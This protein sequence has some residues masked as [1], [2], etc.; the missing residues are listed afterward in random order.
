[1]ADQVH[2]V[3]YCYVTVPARAGQGAKVLG[4]LKRAG[5]NMLGFDGFP[6]GRGKAQL[7]MVVEN[8]GA[9]RRLAGKQG[10]RLSATKKAFLV[11][12]RDRAGA[13]HDHLEKLA[14]AKVNV[15]AAQAVT[16]RDGEYGMVVWVKPR[17]YARAARAL[18][19]K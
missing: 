12:G 1:M 6:A 3:N 14:A 16:T 8:P 19:A 15:T 13:C 11:R 7:D 18:G 17:D 5:I 10:W 4:E 9:L 2:K